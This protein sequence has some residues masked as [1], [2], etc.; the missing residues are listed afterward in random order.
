[1]LPLVFGADLEWGA[2]MR[3]WR[4]TYLPYG[5]EGDGGTAFPFNMGI[6]A[7]G[8][9]SLAELAGRITAREARAVGIHWVFAPVVDINSDPD[10]PIVNVRSYGSDPALVGAYAAAFIRGA[11]AGGVLTTAKHFPG[12]GDTHVDS[13]VGLSVIDVTLDT[14]EV[15]ELRPF[16][17]AVAAGVTSIMLGH[18]A[19]PALTGGRIVPATLAPEIGSDLLRGRIGFRGLVV[20]DAMTMGALRDVEGY[21]PGEIAVRA[22]EAGADV[23]L[24]PPDALLAHRALVAAVRSGRIHYT[25]VDSSVARILR[26]KARL[27]LHRDRTVAL[28]SVPLI[29]GAP[30]HETVA[31]DIAARSLTLVRD[32]ARLIPLD[33]RRIRSLAV[34]AFSAAG[35]VRAGAALAAELRGIYGRGVSF[36]RID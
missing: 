3:L 33:P 15:R 1:R 13:H 31:A 32:S 12:H 20:T 27:G 17:A 8:D 30:E 21:S 16:R 19:V 35:D 4:P 29:V 10:N 23:V 2:G 6:A 5:I 28:D 9:V 7:T 25:R 34:V 24:S 36:I 14:L 11:T 26:A 22:V 18:I